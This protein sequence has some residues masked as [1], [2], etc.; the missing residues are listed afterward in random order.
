MLLSSFAIS[1]HRTIS[2]LFR[3]HPHPTQFSKNPP[4]ALRKKSSVR[5]IVGVRIGVCRQPAEEEEEPK[6]QFFVSPPHL[7]GRTDGASNN[8]IISPSSHAGNWEEGTTNL[9]ILCRRGKMGKRERR[10][11]KRLPF[12]HFLLP[13]PIPQHFKVSIGR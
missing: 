12:L 11:T 4:A 6:P 1:R 3:F 7:F 2:S 9:K 10:E 8:V 13:P 5:E